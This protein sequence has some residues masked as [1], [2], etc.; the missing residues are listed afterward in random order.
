MRTL[1]F[2]LM[3]VPA[4]SVGLVLH[5]SGDGGRWEVLAWG[6]TFLTATVAIW[7]GQQA[8]SAEFRVRTAAG[9]VRWLWE[10][11]RP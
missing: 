4:A 6:L 11:A 1:R 7:L 10:R 8:S 2:G 3:V 5:L 9:A